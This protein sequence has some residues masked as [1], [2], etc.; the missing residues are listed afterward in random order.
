MIALLAL[1]AFALVLYYIFLLSRHVELGLMSLLAAELFDF[2]FGASRNLLGGI[3]LDPTDAVSICLL[4]AGLIRTGQTLKTVNLT[5]LLGIGYLVLFAF[6]LGRGFFF[7]GILT[8]ANE[9]RSFVGPLAAILYFLTA[10]VDDKSLRRY[11]SLYLLFGAALCLVAILAA[12]GLPVGMTAWASTDA[13]V[14][15][16][17][18]PATGAEAVAVCS[19]ISLALLR[20]WKG[21]I[22]N[23][24]VPMMFFAIAIYLRHR[25]IW[26]MILAGTIALIP[27]DFK[28]FRRLL[29]AA[30]IAVAAVAALAVYGGA[31]QGL[32][33]AD[34]FSR[35][36][37][38][39]QTW[40]W[41]L[42]GWKE[43]LFDEEQNILTVSI[44]KSMGSGYSRID[45][46]SYQMVDVGPHSEYVQEFLRVGIVGT[47]FIVLFVLRP[48][49]KLWKL[50]KL[51]PNAVYPS[52]SAW[53]IIVF[54]TLVYGIAYSID[55]HAYALL[56]IANAISLNL[57]KP[58][59]DFRRDIEGEWELSALPTLAE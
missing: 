57:N 43:L 13:G 54:L 39:S 18:L 21:G 31:V 55:P 6:S 35:S 3:H 27:L 32:V 53:A 11:M 37:T 33:D 19:F 46:D 22:V 4:A 45:P 24:L 20:Y 23:R 10:P 25:T 47:L 42:N 41:R 5:R 34:Q 59:E 50:T 44:G 26:M 56:G 58:N 51:D 7:N 12:A 2:A 14:D 36:A 15:G 40:E 17:Y 9:S 1:A 29:P 49:P 28:L 48:L 30:L 16:R 8:A 52:A 38:S